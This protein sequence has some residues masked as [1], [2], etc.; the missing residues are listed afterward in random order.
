VMS[1]AAFSK[2]SDF[3]EFPV[4]RKFPDFSGILG[5]CS[6]TD[7]APAAVIGVDSSAC[8]NTILFRNSALLR[9]AHHS[10]MSSAAL[11]IE[12]S[13]TIL[14]DIMDFFAVGHFCNLFSLQAEAL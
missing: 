12:T 7:P 4:F 10:E 3:R 13:V 14:T 8:P 11:S 2:F 6:V 9:E 5:P 1:H